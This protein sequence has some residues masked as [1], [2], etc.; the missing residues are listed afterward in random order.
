MN[1]RASLKSFLHIILFFVIIYVLLSLFKNQV[2]DYLSSYPLLFSLF[3]HVKSTI[4]SKSLLG[5][6]YLVFV[7]NLFFIMLPVELAAAYYFTLDYSPLIVMAVLVASTVAAQLI[8]FFVGFLLGR[9]V[10]SL[11]LKNS[12]SSWQTRS[13]RWGFFMLAVFS[14]V[15]FLPLDAVTLFL[16]SMHYSFRKF[17]LWVSVMSCLKYVLVYYFSSWAVSSLSSFWPIGLF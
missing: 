14:M 17:V 2:M 4:E 1:R 13:E 3:N 10:F 11:I 5:L 8:N 9:F 6:A 16:G 12:F 15:P 7:G